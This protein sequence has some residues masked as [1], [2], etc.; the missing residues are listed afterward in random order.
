MKLNLKFD[1]FE[2]FWLCIAIVVI[3]GFLYWPKDPIYLMSAKP[4][5]PKVKPKKIAP[6]IIFEKKDPKYD[7]VEPIK[8]P[9]TFRRGV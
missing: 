3:A 8:M 6:K 9:G 5:I 4:D 1:I 7:I 2:F